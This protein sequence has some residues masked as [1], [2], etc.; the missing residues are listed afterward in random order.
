MLAEALLFNMPRARGA[1]DV[2]VAVVA[3][4]APAAC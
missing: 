3:V 4:A 2:A 1:L